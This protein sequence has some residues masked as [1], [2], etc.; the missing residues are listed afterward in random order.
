MLPWWVGVVLAAVF[1][2]VLHSVATQPVKATVQPGQAGAFAAQHIWRGFATVG[3]YILPLICLAGAGLSAW[4]RRERRTLV[5]NAVQSKSADALDGMSWTQFEKLVG[6][7]FRLQGYTVTES[8]GGGADGGVDLVLSRGG[9]KFLVQCKQWKA[10]RV[11]VD[12]VRELYGVMAARGAAG[13]YVVTSG[14]FTDD[15]TGFARGRNVDLIDGSKLHGLIQ[16]AQAARQG[17]RGPTNLPTAG[18]RPASPGSESSAPTCPL[19]SRPMVK[20]TARRG[21]GAGGEFWGCTGYPDCRGT[22]AAD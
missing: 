8:G 20:R 1:Y 19:C 2:V 17:F 12:V 22:R 14:R 13:G 4:R 6:E 7:A 15:A 16:Q 5:Q 18:S 11:G 9:E 3:Q 21:A 10:F